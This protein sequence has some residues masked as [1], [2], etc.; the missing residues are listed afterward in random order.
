MS[1]ASHDRT[2]ADTIKFMEDDVVEVVESG[3]HIPG[4]GCGTELLSRPLF[5]IPHTVYCF[6]S[7]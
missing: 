7:T 5:S 6:T 3:E 1:S 2:A 4:V